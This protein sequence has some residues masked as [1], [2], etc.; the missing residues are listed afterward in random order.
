MRVLVVED[1]VALADIIDR[2]LQ[3]EGFAVE[4]THDGADGLWRAREHPYSAIILDL[5]LPGMN[6]FQVCR[7]LRAEGIWT[8]ILVLTAK[9]GEWDE[10][11]AL[12][13]GADDF[14]SKPFSFVVLVA[15]LRALVRR[16]STPRAAVLSAGTLVLDPF[17]HSCHRRGVEVHLTP[18]EFSVLASLL[19]REG[20]VVSKQEIL[21]EVW[22]HEFGGDPNIVE[23]YV[24]YLRKK[25][26]M[27]FGLDTIETVRHVGYRMVTDAA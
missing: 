22:G 26:D 3:A 6:G 4:V 1:E 15:R 18:R 20:G 27:P 2:G 9:T 7:N 5:L 21:D 23:V 11:E 13:T 25:I 8:P 24:R 17:T 10:A 14:L 19:R 16:G 12:D